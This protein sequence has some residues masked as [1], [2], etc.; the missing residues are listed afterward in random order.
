M[1]GVRLEA[2]GSH[3]GRWGERV[4]GAPRDAVR[5]ALI[6]LARGAH[7]LRMDGALTI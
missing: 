4:F 7:D 2:D 1:N 5:A 3:Q 6:V